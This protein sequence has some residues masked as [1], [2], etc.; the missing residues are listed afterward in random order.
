MLLGCCHCGE[1]VS[2]SDSV[3]E[4]ASESESLVPPTVGGCSSCLGGVAPVRYKLSVFTTSTN[5]CA[6]QYKGDYILTLVQDGGSCF[7]KSAE[8]PLIRLG[9]PGDCLEHSGCVTNGWRWQVNLETWLGSFNI[10]ATSFQWNGSACVQYMNLVGIQGSSATIRN[11]LS[12]ANLAGTV[13]GVSVTA[14]LGVS[15]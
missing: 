15:P 3:S 8:K 14:T 5:L 12:G 11:C 13:G 1:D 6:Q 7:W 10:R 2:D 9:A 4:S